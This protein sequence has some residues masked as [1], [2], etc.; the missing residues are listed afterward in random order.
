MYFRN[1]HFDVELNRTGDNHLEL[2][3][4]N[5]DLLKK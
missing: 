5:E 4:F 1:S 3:C 2:F